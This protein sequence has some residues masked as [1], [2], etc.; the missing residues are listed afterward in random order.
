MQSHELDGVCGG[1]F[2][3]VSTAGLKSHSLPLWSL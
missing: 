2:I 3:V 1:V